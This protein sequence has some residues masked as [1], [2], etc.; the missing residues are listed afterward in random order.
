MRAEFNDYGDIRIKP[1]NSLE[2][3][4]WRHIIE[5]ILEGTA[6]FK[7][8]NASYHSGTPGPESILIGLAKGE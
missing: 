4:I 1:E 7:I 5:Q 2:K 6:L 8:L 3:L